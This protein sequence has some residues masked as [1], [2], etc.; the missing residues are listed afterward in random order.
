MTAHS[1]WTAGKRHFD[2]AGGGA[3]GGSE[4][5][6]LH[7]GVIF[8]VTKVTRGVTCCRPTLP[9]RRFA[10][11]RR[12]GHFITVNERNIARRMTSRG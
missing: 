7:E 8:I 10:L 2:S 1:P 9:V 11:S 12:W 3:G 5:K 6:L 4:A